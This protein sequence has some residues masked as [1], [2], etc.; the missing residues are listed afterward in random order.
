MDSTQVVMLGSSGRIRDC[1][2]CYR[3]KMAIFISKYGEKSVDS[4]L[5]YSRYLNDLLPCRGERSR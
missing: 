2:T 5:T 4:K 1:E 3:S